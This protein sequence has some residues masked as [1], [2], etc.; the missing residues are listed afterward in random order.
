MGTQGMVD[1]GEKVATTLRR[2]FCEEAMDVLKADESSREQLLRQVD[3]WFA[4]GA[5]VSVSARPRSPSLGRVSFPLVFDNS[6]ALDRII[7][8]FDPHAHIY[9]L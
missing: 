8:M 7:R 9:Y 1:A 3:Q 2:E 5:E 6:Y 4:G